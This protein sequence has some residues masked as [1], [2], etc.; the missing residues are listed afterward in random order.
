MLQSVA[1]ITEKD[2]IIKACYLFNFT[3]GLRL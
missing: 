1:D 3:K 2:A